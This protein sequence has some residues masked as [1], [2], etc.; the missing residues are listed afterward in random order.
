MIGPS[1]RFLA[2]ALSTC[3]VPIEFDASQV[4][5]RSR[6]IGVTDDGRVAVDLVGTRD[7]GLARA[8]M[9]GVMDEPF[10][11]DSPF[12]VALRVVLQAQDPRAM[13]RIKEAVREVL[14]SRIARRARIR[15]VRLSVGCVALEEGEYAIVT[16]RLPNF[17]LGRRI[18]N[19]E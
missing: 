18:A 8:T 6:R 1:L 2:W 9:V 19:A 11:E 5:G 4:G 7:G 16:V 10:E 3:P 15:G 17:A 12:W 14:R 13:A